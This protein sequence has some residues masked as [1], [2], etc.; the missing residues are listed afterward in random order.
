MEP[1]LTEDEMRRMANATRYVSKRAK[2]E[3]FSLKDPAKGDYIAMLF[4]DAL[5]H[6]E[7]CSGLPPKPDA[8]KPET[9]DK[10][11]E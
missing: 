2:E 7:L 1:K 6:P 5:L 11:Q 10:P 4:Q 9:G 8:A 3:G